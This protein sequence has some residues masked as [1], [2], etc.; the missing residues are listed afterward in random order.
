MI[1]LVHED[2]YVYI[3]KI[4]EKMNTLSGIN[5]F[6]F[7]NDSTDS[8]VDPGVV[9]IIA[10]SGSYESLS[11]Y[12]GFNTITI[13]KPLSEGDIMVLNLRD[14]FY[15]LNGVPFLLDGALQME[16]D[17][18][19]TLSLSFVGSGGLDVTYRRNQVFEN[20]MDLFFCTGLDVSQNNEIIKSVNIKAET[21]VR[22]TAKKDYQW[23]I[24]GLWNDTELQKFESSSGLFRLRLV[25]E[26][27]LGL[28]KL[29][30]CV[31]ASFQKGSSDSG[32]YN[33]ALNGS[34]D[35]IF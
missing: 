26:D 4:E 9:E 1:T 34:F 3:D 24:N 19:H 5:T 32:D 35:K 22:K 6:D 7:S 12:A 31:I 8:I 14:R 28:E 17:T 23:S 27:G 30:N 33:Y 18:N 2:I 29:A 10:K 20:D 13:N 15:T 25:D 11:M 16:N 21:K